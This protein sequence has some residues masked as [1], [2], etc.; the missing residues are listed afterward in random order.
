M[1][2]LLDSLRRLT[3]ILSKLTRH[4]ISVSVGRNRV[5]GLAGLLA[6]CCSSDFFYKLTRSEDTPFLDVQSPLK[7][8]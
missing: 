6:S 5:Q 7:S 1:Q 4:L 8:A 3:S 2:I